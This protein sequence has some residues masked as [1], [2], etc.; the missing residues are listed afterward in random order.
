[1]FDNSTIDKVDQMGL[2]KTGQNC[3]PT[4]FMSKLIIG[5]SLEKVP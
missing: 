1:M 2:W 3:S 4:H 5:L